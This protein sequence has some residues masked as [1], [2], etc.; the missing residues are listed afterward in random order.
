MGCGTAQNA[1][2][3]LALCQLVDQLVHV[4]NLLHQRVLDLLHSHAANDA[5]DER[6]VWMNGWCLREEG[7][8]VALPFDLLLQPRLV[9]PRQPADW[10]AAGSMDTDLSFLSLLEL[11]RT[12]VS[13]RRVPARRVVEPLDV[14]EHVCPRLFTRPVH[15]SRRAL[16]LQ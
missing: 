9:V 6:P 7:F 11:Y 12:D 2:Q 4:A 15:L 14:V 13:E 1:L 8:E 16:G 3:S 5:R 10:A